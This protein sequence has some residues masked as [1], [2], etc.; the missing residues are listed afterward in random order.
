MNSWQR[1]LIITGL[2]FLASDFGHA[3][4]WLQGEKGNTIIPDKVSETVKIDGELS[5]NVWNNSPLA[6]ELITFYPTDKEVLGQKTELW[7]A[8][9]R[10]NLYFAAKCYDTE[11]GKIK[12]SICRR[13]NISNDDWLGVIIDPMGNRQS[14][15]EFYVNPN[16][17]QEDGITSAVNGLTIDKSPDFVWESASKM[18]NEGYQMEI[19][20]PLESI[21]YKGDK[22]TKMGIM[23]MRYVNH[24]GKMGSWPEIKSGQTQFHFMAT[25][26]YNDLQKTLNLEILPNFTFSSNTGR[27]DVDTWDKSDISREFGVSLKYGITSS[28]TIEGTVNPD[29]S[30]VESD[31]FQVEVNQRYPVSYSEKRP[32]F[33]EG[34]HA[35]DFGIVNQGLMVSTAYTRRIIEPDWAAKLSGTAGK[36]LFTVLAANDR[37]ADPLQIINEADPL[38]SINVF[39]GIARA[40]YNLGGDNSLGILYSGSHFDGGKNDVLGADFQYRFLKKARFTASYLYSNTLRPNKTVIEKGNGFNA[41]LQYAAREFATWLTYE[42]YDG[43]FFMSSAFLNESNLSRVQ[44]YAGPNFYPKD[45]FFSSWIRKIHPYIKYATQRNLD[46][47]LDENSWRLGMNLF[48][49]VSG[50]AKIEFHDDK[51][52]CKGQFFKP[53]RFFFYGGL[54]LFKW[55]YVEGTF[56]SGGRVSYRSAS[57]FLG[58]WNSLRVTSAIQS[59]SNLSIYLEF[60]HDDFYQESPRQRVYTLD[61]YNL[62]ATY[63]FNRYFFVRGALRYNNN[64]HVLITDFLASLTLIPGSVVHLGYGSLYDDRIRDNGTLLNSKNSLFFKISYLLRVK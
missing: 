42:R 64:S 2:I 55:L 53:R 56:I 59:S 27:L 15:Y 9:D 12:S 50:F 3:V 26:V 44:V 6:N 36:V 4:E 35:F 8:Y 51:E 11:P 19:C 32:F 33:M 13:D 62:L 14:S 48:F 22:E 21:R 54:Q 16:G 17:I 45:T 20:I 43:G 23:F 7:V 1:V 57:P 46:N 47:R 18:T 38:Q 52:L 58:S 10:R 63:Q 28:V 29:F 34:T 41:M 25:T 31:A 5:E 24:L 40:K 49:T 39:W 61:I 30:Q 37:A 60:I